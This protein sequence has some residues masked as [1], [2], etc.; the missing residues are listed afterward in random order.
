MSLDTAWQIEQTWGSNQAVL[1]AVVA[2][3]HPVTA[4]ECGCGNYSTP[5]LAAGVD[6]LHSI[7]HDR[8]WAR[9]V[10]KRFPESKTHRYSVLPLQGIRNGTPHD[11]VPI[12]EHEQITRFYES[13]VC[14][15]HDFVLVDTFRCARVAAAL[16]LAKSTPLLMLHDVEPRSRDYYNYH[17]FD[18]ALAGWHRYEHRPQG[19]VNK[20]HQI[21]WTALYSREPLDLALL[22]PTVIGESIRLWGQS[23]CLEEIRG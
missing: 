1:K 18:A 14:E 5:I 4:I 2:G 23:V 20:V 13:L 8:R 3:L 9:E 6:Y 7:E 19:F 17:A 21:P 22:Q 12:Q 16:A 10:Q 15:I 11:E